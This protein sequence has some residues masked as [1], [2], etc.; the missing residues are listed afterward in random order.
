[1]HPAPNMSWRRLQELNQVR[2]QRDNIE[3]ALSLAQ[4]V[5]RRHAN[6]Q[7][8]TPHSQAVASPWG[9]TAP[10][11]T[12]AWLRRVLAMMMCQGD[13]LCGKHSVLCRALPQE[14]AALRDDNGKLT[15]DARVL[16][17]H[18]GELQARDA[19]LCKVLRCVKADTPQRTHWL[20]SPT[21]WHCCTHSRSSMPSIDRGVPV[22]DTR[23][24]R[25]SWI[26]YFHVCQ[27]IAKHAHPATCVKTRS[28]SIVRV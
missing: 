5:R 11:C 14:V 21:G 18:N 20:R 4:K 24:S 13:R 8:L 27:R 2:C 17:Q 10:H 6:L 7:V 28:C 23:V 25:L 12:C 22:P 9:G 16:Q 19:R 15:K 1:V 3:N 26:A